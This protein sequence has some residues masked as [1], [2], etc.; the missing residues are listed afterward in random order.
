[1]FIRTPSMRALPEPVRGGN[2]AD[3][4]QLVNVR[5]RDRGLVT[6]AMVECLRPETPYPV[7]VFHGE[8]GSAKSRGQR[9]IRDVIDPNDVSLRAAPKGREDIQIAACNNHVVSYENLS[10]L[11]S[12]FQDDFCVLS[13]GGGFAQRTLYKNAEETVRRTK[14][15]VMLNGISVTVTA[16][17]LLSRTV[18]IELQKIEHR[19]TDTELDA[20]FAAKQPGILGGLLDIFVAALGFIDGIKIAPTALPRMADFAVLGE[21]VYSALGKPAG[22]FLEDYAENQE[23]GME[24][25][26]EASTV[27]TAIM[28]KL[29]DKAGAKLDGTVGALW[30]SLRPE[31]G[32]WPADAK[33][34]A[35]QLRLMT[36]AML[37]QGVS[38][39]ISDKRSKRGRECVI[40]RVEA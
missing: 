2:F 1:M 13:T 37:R 28:A 31:V 33:G 16:P 40:V 4:W 10:R 34:F 38:I 9:T 18:L 20:V 7:L 21:A 12:Q 36:P 27:A 11:S 32:E 15:P 24:Q 8:F 5:E 35:A 25:S 23:A 3:L 29:G 6:A 22:T 19:K 39:T 26:L 30:Q 14:R 17:D